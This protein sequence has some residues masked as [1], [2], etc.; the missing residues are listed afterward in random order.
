MHVKKFL[1]WIG[2]KER[3]HSIVHEAPHVSEG[4]IWWVSIGENVGAEI[5]GKNYLFSRP[6]IIFRKL[7]HGFYFVIP[8]TTQLRTGTWYVS[9][10]QQGREM[11]ACLQHARS[12]DHRRLSTRLGEL[13]EVDYK[14]VKNGF[15]KLYL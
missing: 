9:F 7:T 6:A 13:D 12:V 11:T 8:V 2:L 10:S 3:L 5:N 14:R 15:Q 4:E 1:E